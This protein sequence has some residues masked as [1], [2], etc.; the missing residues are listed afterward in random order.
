MSQVSKNS[1]DPEID[2]SVISKKIGDFFSSIAT[3]AFEAILF[4]KRNLIV[5]SF[6]VLA[7]VVIG[8]FLDK[9]EDRFN[10]N[11]IVGSNFGSTEYLYGKVELL[12]SKIK[13]GDTTFLKSIGVKHPKKLRIIEIEPIVDIYNFVNNSSP[14]MPSG[15]QNTQNFELVKLLSESS[16]INKVIKEETTSKNYTKHMIHVE[17]K[18]MISNSDSVDPILKYLNENSYY[19]AIQASLVNN[20]SKKMVENEGII[21]Q[22]NALLDQFS[23]EAANNQRNDKLVYYNNENNQINDIINTKNGLIA[24]LGNQRIQLINF[25]KTIKDY[26]RIINFRKKQGTLGKMKVVLPILLMILFILFVR[27]KRFYRYQMRKRTT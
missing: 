11:I 17:S 12:N 10:T 4:V 15:A 25:D 1:G 8:F 21:R 23:N 9:S 6:L 18:G 27:I 16:D 24:E 20:I 3:A 7:G 13:D 22:I 19:N 14:N 5:F 26:S 2:L